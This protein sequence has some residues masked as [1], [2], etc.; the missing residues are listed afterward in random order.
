MG[1]RTHSS[2]S[3]VGLTPYMHHY[4]TDCLLP[5]STDSFDDTPLDEFPFT[6]EAEVL[7]KPLGALIDEISIKLPKLDLQH[8]HYVLSLPPFVNSRYF[9]HAQQAGTKTGRMTINEG[10][11]GHSDR[12]TH[13]M[14]NA[15]FCTYHIH[16]HDPLCSQGGPEGGVFDA[17]VIDYSSSFFTITWLE[18]FDPYSLRRGG[19]AD[20][21]LGGRSVRDSEYWA[22]MQARVAALV[23]S[24]DK[25][26]RQDD[27]ERKSS[28]GVSPNQVIFL[29]ELGAD[30]L[31]RSF[32]NDAFAGTR[33][34]FDTV[35]IRDSYGSVFAS[36]LS[37]AVTAKAIMD[38]PEPQNCDE[39]LECEELRERIYEEARSSRQDE[40]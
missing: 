10:W 8:Q 25:E 36:A 16:P 13:R 14:Y 35:T 19:F 6:R 32:L 7:H 3:R 21:G 24:I 9:R 1:E 12:T 2:L 23:R 37:A 4:S 15:L 17:L 29:G 28:L 5:D 11:V 31:L 30:E 34:A 38:A 39:R 33:F 27:D 26:R 22:G 40:L 20:G 18:T